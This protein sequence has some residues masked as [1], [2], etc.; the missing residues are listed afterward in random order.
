MKLG[1]R[2]KMALIVAGFALPIV[3][4]FLV[5]TFGHPRATANY[6]ELLL[7]PDTVTAAH[8][9]GADGRDFRFA[10]LGGRWIIVV[11]DRAPCDAACRAKLVAVRQVRLTLGKDAERVA[12]VAVLEGGAAPDPAMRS[13]FPDMAFVRPAQ[14]A[15]AGAATADPAHIYLVDPNGNVMMR[16]PAQP[17]YKRMKGDLDRLLRASQIG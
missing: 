9:V 14:P 6:G 3:A 4:S 5:Y 15:P 17:D 13:E 12:T 7:P 11:G 16:W 1:P 2:A 10:S 8:F